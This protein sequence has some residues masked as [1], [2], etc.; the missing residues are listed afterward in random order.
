MRTETIRPLSGLREQSARRVNPTRFLYLSFALLLFALVLLGFRQFFLHGRAVSGQELPPSVRS[1]LIIHGVA[2]TGWMALFIIQPLLIVGHNR[3]LHILLGMFGTALAALIV[4]LG[5]WTA[6]ATTKRIDTDLVRYGLHRRQFMAVPLIDILGFLTF[7]GVGIWKRKRP[8]IH[9]PMM[10]L[11][12]LA[13]MA[14]ATNRIPQFRGLGATN[15]LGHLFGP[16]LVPLAIG[17]L[18]LATKSVLTRTIDRWFAI[19]LAASVV[20][21]ILCMQIASSAAWDR[22]A[23][24]L[25]S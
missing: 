13:M 6:I 17:V 12:T 19:G 11:G 8:E 20:V 15:I 18:F 2:M 23:T 4:V 14:A 7:V 16:H 10:L 3:R 21:S 24:A 22:I 1:L 9:R 25:T 5:T